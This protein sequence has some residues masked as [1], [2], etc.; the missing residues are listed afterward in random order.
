[1]VGVL[2]RAK[3]VPAKVDT[4]AFR[5]S[6]HAT[7]IKLLAHDD[8][9]VL[10]CKLLGHPCSPESI[11]FETENFSTVDVRSSNGQIETRFETELMIV[12]DG[13][14]FKTSFS[15]ANRS[16]NV[17]PI[18][19][20]RRAIHKRF[21]VDISKAGVPKKALGNAYEIDE[22]LDEEYSEQ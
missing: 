20:G 14:E 7:H 2:G 18:L 6:I 16:R 9:P 4:G 1:M 8:K 15:L 13:Q 3:I 11:D 17:F 19:I 21:L 22:T 12:I 10:K 5:S